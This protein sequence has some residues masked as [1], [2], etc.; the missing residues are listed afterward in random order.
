MAMM[1]R[2]TCEKYSWKL[3]DCGEVWVRNRV[4]PI[5]LINYGE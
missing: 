1:M 2:Y 3:L 5:I 4:I